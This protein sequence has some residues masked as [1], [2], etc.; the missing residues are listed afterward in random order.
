MKSL[1]VHY[2]RTGN[3]RIVAEAT[4]KELNADLDEIIDLKKRSGP[5]GWLRAGYDSGRRKLTRIRVKKNPE[6]Y[7]VIVV[8]TPIWNNNMTPA[9]RTYLTNH[10]LNGKKLAF[11]CTAG[12]SDF[13]N[14]FEGMKELVPESAVLGTLGI[15]KKEL[16]SGT[17]REKIQTFI[18]ALKK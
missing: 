5:L 18:L 17:Y 16:E 14:A 9:V 4:A 7:S 6:S 11:F 8:G 1:V 3:T 15:S 12:G 13:K 10:N 2:S